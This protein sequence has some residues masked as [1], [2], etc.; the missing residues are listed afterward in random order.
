MGCRAYS[1]EDEGRLGRV[2]CG[3]MI[4]R[5][6]TQR[7]LLIHGG[8]VGEGVGK[9]CSGGA[10]GTRTPYLFNAIEALSQMSYSP[11]RR[12]RWEGDARLNYSKAGVQRQRVVLVQYIWDSLGE[13]SF[14]WHCSSLA[15]FTAG[16][17]DLSVCRRNRGL[18][19][20][21]DEYVRGNIRTNK[22][23]TFGCPP[24]PH[25]R[26]RP[27]QHTDNHDDRHEYGNQAG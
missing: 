1:E 7:V 13:T 3:L 14:V 4:L 21:E 26:P 9:S 20:D 8:L 2:Y 11:T 25:P 17:S 10:G 5:T 22:H 19:Q 15:A 24:R 16:G 27:I 6:A 18:C 12:N 23:A